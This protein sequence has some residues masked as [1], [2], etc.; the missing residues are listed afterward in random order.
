MDYKS[1]ER[2]DATILAHNFNVR[3]CHAIR[4]LM[5]DKYRRKINIRDRYCGQ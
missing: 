5:W 1:D 4:P 3:N 2:N